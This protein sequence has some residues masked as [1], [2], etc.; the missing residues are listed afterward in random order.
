MLVVC[1][2][3]PCLFIRLITLTVEIEKGDDTYCGAR[4]STSRLTNKV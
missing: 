2:M 4:V 1:V 3:L